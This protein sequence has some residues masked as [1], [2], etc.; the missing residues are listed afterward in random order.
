ML[1]IVDHILFL[2][3]QGNLLK[4]RLTYIYLSLGFQTDKIQF[5]VIEMLEWLY[6]SEMKRHMSIEIYPDYANPTLPRDL[7]TI[8]NT[9][10]YGFASIHSCQSIISYKIILQNTKKKKM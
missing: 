6:E 5:L 2:A 8:N 3:T 1:S 4:F 10:K 9:R 7:N